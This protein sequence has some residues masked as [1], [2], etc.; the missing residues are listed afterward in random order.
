M[1]E[2]QLVD[3]ARET[4]EDYFF[5]VNNSAKHE[6]EIVSEIVNVG[7]IRITEAVFSEI[8]ENG[9]RKADYHDIFSKKYRDSVD[10]L[11]SVETEEV[12]GHLNKL[13]DRLSARMDSEHLR[14][15]KKDFADLLEKIIHQVKNL[16]QIAKSCEKQY[17]ADAEIEDV[18]ESYYRTPIENEVSWLMG[19]IS[20]NLES[21]DN[22]LQFKYGALL[23]AAE[24]EK[25]TPSEVS[26]ETNKM[27]VTMTWRKSKTDLVE[28]IKALIETKSIE[29]ED[30]KDVYSQFSKL[31]ELELKPNDSLKGVRR[32]KDPSEHFTA[33]LNKAILDWIEH[34]DEQNRLHR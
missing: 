32:K 22:S 20:R 7:L 34:R 18:N 1:E 31:F 5:V 8:F 24:V 26:I 6:I 17:G 21:I 15:P 19:I 11:V 12:K 10:I 29:Y 13:F 14:R 27:P 9:R 16:Y 4:V 28:L 30:E 23:E 3:K 33:I 25:T 2:K